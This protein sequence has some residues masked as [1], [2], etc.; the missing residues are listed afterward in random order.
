[1]MLDVVRQASISTPLAPDVSM[2]GYIASP[3]IG[4][5]MCNLS[6]TYIAPAV[7]A[8][9]GVVMATQALHASTLISGWADAGSPTPYGVA[10]VPD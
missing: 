10:A 4:A 9:V 2:M 7:P 1:M 5:R 3:R 6:H 8:L